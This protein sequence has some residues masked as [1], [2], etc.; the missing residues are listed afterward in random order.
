VWHANSYGQ[1]RYLYF[2]EEKTVMSPQL[3]NQVIVKMSQRPIRFHHYLWH[4][5][6]T[7]WSRLT[8]AEQ[9]A[10]R[11]INPAQVAPRPSLDVARRPMRD[12]D[13]GE[14]KARTTQP[15]LER[16]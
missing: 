5:V 16:N 2:I 11:D 13:A 6:R 9:Q 14:L 15:R 10:V 7:T 4:R 12:N 1:E 3:P 8:P